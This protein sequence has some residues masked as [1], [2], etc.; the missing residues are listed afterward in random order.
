MDECKGG[1]SPFLISLSLIIIIT[2]S[3]EF[4]Y[5]F[6][7]SLLRLFFHSSSSFIFGLQRASNQFADTTI[8]RPTHRSSRGQSEPTL[9]KHLKSSFFHFRIAG[10]YLYYFHCK[11]KEQTV[12]T[13]FISFSLFKRCRF[14]VKIQK[15]AR[16]IQKRNDNQNGNSPR[17]VNVPAIG[18]NRDGD[19]VWSR[20][21]STSATNDV[22]DWT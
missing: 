17:D 15:E 4:L 20:E 18:E 3:F 2:F 22:H 16:A 6:F 11:E 12:E 14:T 10:W 5:F 1:S 21:K 9:F 19:A 7:F 13:L 8:A